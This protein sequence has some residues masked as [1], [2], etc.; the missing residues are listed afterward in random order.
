[1]FISYLYFL[2]YKL[3]GY[4]G[5]FLVIVF[6]HSAP[7]ILASFWFIWNSSM[8]VKDI[9]PLFISFFSSSSS[10]FPLIW[11]MYA[12]S[13]QS[14]PTPCNPMDCSPPGSSVHGILQ[15]RILEWVAILSSRGYSRPRDQTQ[16][17]YVSCT[18]RRVL[19]HH[20]HLASPSLIWYLTFNFINVVFDIWECVQI[21]NLLNTVLQRADTDDTCTLFVTFL[22]LPTNSHPLDR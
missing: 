3:T 17:S 6:A 7:E 16:V 10:L 9:N 1:M 22:V 15:A 18:G 8:S 14:C 5:M 20:C 21:I 4:L 11:C 12:K 2:V 19:C 13:L